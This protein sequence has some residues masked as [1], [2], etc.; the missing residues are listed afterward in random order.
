MSALSRFG[1]ALFFCR[2]IFIVDLVY[3]YFFGLGSS[4]LTIYGFYTNH[5]TFF[6]NRYIN[7]YLV[8]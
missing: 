7:L 3:I 8:T 2:I 1:H 6:M 4:L 5:G